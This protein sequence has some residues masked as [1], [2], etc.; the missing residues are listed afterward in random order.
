MSEFI[1]VGTISNV[2]SA[3]TTYKYIGGIIMENKLK[4]LPYTIELDWNT[5]QIFLNIPSIDS[6]LV[7]DER[8]FASIS[9][10]MNM[11]RNR[12]L[13]RTIKVGDTFY[14]GNKM[15]QYKIL[16]VTSLEYAKFN[17][18]I[19]VTEEVIDLIDGDNHVETNLCINHS[20]KDACVFLINAETCDLIF[21]QFVVAAMI[22][23]NNVE[24]II[25]KPFSE[26]NKISDDGSFLYKRL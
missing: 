7:L 12:A 17:Q 10:T 4:E 23:D 9:D 25:A 5:G 21:G 16:D 2:Y 15:V 14:V 1:K 8:A 11:S 18:D 3:F 26:M 24:K 13:L 19:E 22:V 20:Q 6:K